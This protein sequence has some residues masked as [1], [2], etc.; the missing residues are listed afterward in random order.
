MTQIPWRPGVDAFVATRRNVRRVLKNQADRCPGARITVAVSETSTTCESTCKR[1]TTL[2]KVEGTLRASW[3][4]AR[5]LVKLQRCL[6]SLQ[7]YSCDR[8]RVFGELA[9][10]YGEYLELGETIGREVD[11][12]KWEPIDQ[13]NSSG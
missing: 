9:G 11:G 2:V 1:T 12:R 10:E 7:I 3:G 4:I 8:S 5:Y 13:S 6:S